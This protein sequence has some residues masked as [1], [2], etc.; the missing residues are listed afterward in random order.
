MFLGM[1][2]NACQKGLPLVFG[3]LDKNDPHHFGEMERS[4]IREN[5]RDFVVVFS[6]LANHNGASIFFANFR[7]L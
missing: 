4:E 2:K 1:S 3:T 6:F 7:Q 5:Y